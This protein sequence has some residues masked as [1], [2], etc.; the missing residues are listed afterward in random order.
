MLWHKFPLLD[1][2][3]DISF[4]KNGFC[5]CPFSAD[6][7]SESLFFYSLDYFNDLTQMTC[8]LSIVEIRVRCN[9][10]RKPHKPKLTKHLQRSFFFEWQKN[11]PHSKKRTA[12]FCNT[13][14]KRT[15]FMS[16]IIR[17]CS[18]VHL[19]KKNKIEESHFRCFKLPSWMSFS[20]FVVEMIVK[21]FRLSGA[22]NYFDTD[23]VK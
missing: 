16:L 2:S 17:L 13:V 1:K 7:S 19:L 21:S 18:T 3:Q 12:P 15:A 11:G 6:P 20:S 14:S 4:C 8:L 23:R 10:P 9:A 22:F 5:S